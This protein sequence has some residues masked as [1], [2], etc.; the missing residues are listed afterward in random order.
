MAGKSQTTL[1]F[2]YYGLSADFEVGAQ[3]S[4]ICHVGG[5]MDHF[6]YDFLR[7]FN[8]PQGNR[9]KTS[10]NQIGYFN[11]ENFNNKAMSVRDRGGLGGFQLPAGYQIMTRVNSGGPAI[12]IY[13]GEKLAPGDPDKFAGAGTSDYW[14]QL[15][16]DFQYLQFGLPAAIDSSVGSLIT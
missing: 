9:N 8:L 15:N 4:Y 6:I 2:F 10:L 3:L 7:F 11:I 5:I 1:F 14:L 12:N 13:G 16:G